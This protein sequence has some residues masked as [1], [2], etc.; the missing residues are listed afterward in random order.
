MTAQNARMPKKRKRSETAQNEEVPSKKNMDA[1]N[2][3]DGGE[4]DDD[5]SPEKKAKTEPE[6]PFCIKKFLAVL[7][8]GGDL[9][10]ELQKFVE[11]ADSFA[12]GESTEDVVKQYLD[13]ADGNFQSISALL[14][15]VKTGSRTH[16]LVYQA[17]ERLVSRLPEDFKQYVNTAL[18]SAQQMLQKYNRLVHMSLCRT[19]K[20]NHAKAA[21]RLLTAIVTLGPEGARYVTSIINFESTNFIMWINT[22]NRRDAEDVRTCAVFFLM[23]VLVVG[24]NSVARQ[25]LQVKGLINSI[26]PG[27]LYDRASFICSFLS[28]FQAKVV[29][30]TSFTKTIKLKM[31][32]D[33]SLKYVTQLLSWE[34]PKP[35][36]IHGK[37]NKFKAI[38]GTEKEDPEAVL[39]ASK[40]DVELV[41]STAYNF[42]TAV[43]CSHKYGILFRDPK[44][45]QSRQNMNF[46]ITSILLKMEHPYEHERCSSFVVELLKVAPDQIGHYLH[47]WKPILTFATAATAEKLIKLYTRVVEVQ[48]L[49][50]T[51]WAMAENVPEK[52]CRL[53]LYFSLLSIAK[54]VAEARS[55][56]TEENNV[57]LRLAHMRFVA[58]SLRKVQSALHHA[59]SAKSSVSAG[60]KAK[61]RRILCQDVW[62]NVPPTADL[63]KEYCNVV[64]KA[65]SKEPQT[66]GPSLSDCSAYCASILDVLDL[67][68]PF[69]R[70][71][72]AEYDWKVL[73]QLAGVETD[74]LDTQAEDQCLQLRAIGLV[75]EACPA[76]E[77]LMTSDAEQKSPFCHLLELFARRKEGVI[78]KS[79]ASLISKLLCNLNVLEGYSMEVDI[80]MEKFRLGQC[81]NLVQLLLSAIQ[82]V[83]KDSNR[84]NSEVMRN[85]MYLTT[86][87]GGQS[88]MDLWSLLKQSLGT[89]ENAKGMES[90]GVSTYFSPLVPA[91]MECIKD[92]TDTVHKSYVYAVIKAILHHQQ[93]PL[94][95][96]NFLHR[97][98]KSLSKLLLSYVSIWSSNTLPVTRP[99]KEEGVKEFFSDSEQQLERVFLDILYAPQRAKKMASSTV[100]STVDLTSCSLNEC[101]SL[102]YQLMLYARK[103]FE[104]K[105]VAHEFFALLQVLKDV[106]GRAVELR[107]EKEEPGV[108]LDALLRDDMTLSAYL[109]DAQDCLYPL[110][111]NYSFF[112]LDTINHVMQHMSIIPK[113]LQAS[114][115]FVKDKSLKMIS[116]GALPRE[117][118]VSKV[119]Q[120]FTCV[121]NESD[122]LVLLQAV[123]PV[124]SRCKRNVGPL[125]RTWLSCI[126]KGS[127]QDAPLLSAAVIQNML[128]S[129]LQSQDNVSLLEAFL[130]FLEFRPVYVFAFR[131][132]DLKRLLEDQTSAG[133]DIVNFL[134]KHNVQHRQDLQQLIPG[135]FKPMVSH[136]SMA[137]LA[138]FLRSLC[139][140]LSRENAPKKLVAWLAKTFLVLPKRACAMK[141]GL[142]RQVLDDMMSCLSSLMKLGQ[143]GSESVTKLVEILL[144]ISEHQLQLALLNTLCRN[145]SEELFDGSVCDS[146]LHTL[147]QCV[148]NLASSHADVSEHVLQQL[149]EVVATAKVVDKSIFARVVRQDGLWPQFIKNNLKAGFQSQSFGQTSFELLSVVCQKVYS[150][151]NVG[152]I[153]PALCRVYMMMFGHSRFL[154]LMLD[155]E[156]EVQKQKDKMLELMA[157]LVQCDPTLCDVEHIPV[158]LS[159]YRASL[160]IVDQK[161]LYL[162]FLYEKNGVDLCN[163]KPFLWG[164]SAV[165]FY[166]LHKKASVSL[167][168]QPKSEEVLNLINEDKMAATVL[169]FPL[170][171]QLD[172]LPLDS[173]ADGSLYDPRFL[174]PLLFTLL[175]PES[176]VNCRQIVETRCLSLILMSLSSEVFEVRCLG[177]NLVMMLH[178]HLQGSRF[179]MSTVWLSV[180]ETLRNAATVTCPHVPCL[181][182]GYL[183]SAIDVIS[184]PGHFMFNAVADFL[185]A[186]PVLDIENVPDFYKMFYNYRVEHYMKRNWHL[187]VMGDYMRCGLD[188][189]ISKKRY[190]FNILLTFF[191]SPLCQKNTKELILKLLIAA[192]KIPKAARILCR[193]QGFMMWLPAA[194]EKNSGEEG[195]S[196]LL[197]E[198]VHHVW[199]SSFVKTVR[200]K[201]LKAAKT[202][203]QGSLSKGEEASEESADDEEKEDNAPKEEDEAAIIRAKRESLRYYEYFPYEFIL[204]LFSTRKYIMGCHNL[205]A[206]TKFTEELSDMLCFVRSREASG[207]SKAAQNC[208]LPNRDIVLELLN[209]WRQLAATNGAD[210]C[211]QSSQAIASV[212]HHW[213]PDNATQPLEWLEALDFSLQHG[214][215]S[216]NF[217]ED[218]LTWA[219]QWLESSGGPNCATELVNFQGGRC[220]EKLLARVHWL[221]GEIVA[222]GDARPMVTSVVLQIAD[223]LFSKA[224]K[225]L[226]KTQCDLYMKQRVL[227]RVDVSLPEL[228]RALGTS[229]LF[230][231]LLLGVTKT[232]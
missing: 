229:V 139:L 14:Y 73:C 94:V 175:A 27:L 79:A 54:S 80:W 140:G 39:E 95:F 155:T 163:F 18:V 228:D 16:T 78:G 2:D 125:L 198:T 23:S 172:V 55:F 44:M 231:E 9:M 185:L 199:K 107:T 43:C 174:L 110:A 143:L 221:L 190:I 141:K 166:S 92:S 137:S 170:H 211:Q 214:S 89:A 133:I 38:R 202:K 75:L 124:P 146:C 173:I 58:A 112:L 35:W 161:I 30:T 206:F 113:E 20:P 196:E 10:T 32:N 165:S 103:L 208:C 50:S 48:D 85:V 51:L 56:Q 192:A 41:Q 46:V 131:P 26:F 159:A 167:L 62:K 123:G 66:E 84:L 72:H 8:K 116:T 154:P 195:I 119:L 162:M 209:H 99:M 212:C 106:F 109:R 153:N 177:C 204:M 29:E 151:G 152:D 218:L 144:D 15:G 49:D 70:D 22:R 169:R 168:K 81:L 96:C 226:A 90:F 104:M 97:N 145:M 130:R 68:R 3:L 179:N 6:E 193:E 201:D 189:H 115:C 114:L 76:S 194:L 138:G 105:H 69:S 230:N 132:D 178:H 77:A 127:E 157:V 120:A 33:K 180:L 232:E 5:G 219:L 88:A 59:E 111:C 63:V 19:A 12:S 65:T 149:R 28:T 118:D 91:A 210:S 7:D 45:G 93:R 160:S 60:M 98:S 187:E 176:L 4:S 227:L 53:I 215:E 17:L 223:L 101:R 37:W 36:S 47:G 158:F 164:P 191:M 222:S 183:V 57:Q 108:L 100:R 24:S 52:V 213:Q 40:E 82:L 142:T 147:L 224:A 200:V 13:A 128:S 134:M 87:D 86:A 25:V 21:L 11:A 207:K 34:G 122:I 205:D 220:L 181:V 102:F 171:L 135:S 121:F 188:F 150:V 197:F 1:E 184:N 156:D 61:L 225:V 67:Y 186:K 217:N 83:V 136:L 71:H 74:S 42:L 129:I 182:T 117:I 31:L 203:K 148:A 216:V 126:S 64:T